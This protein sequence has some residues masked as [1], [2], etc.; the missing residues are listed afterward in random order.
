MT[1]HEKT[2]GTCLSS[3]FKVQTV[4]GVIIITSRNYCFEWEILLS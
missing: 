4:T 2:T 1:I 3:I